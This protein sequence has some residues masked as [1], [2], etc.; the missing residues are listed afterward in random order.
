MRI[1]SYRESKCI[2]LKRPVHRPFIPMKSDPVMVNRKIGIAN[3]QHVKGNF[4]TRKH[5]HLKL[6]TRKFTILKF[7]LVKISTH[8]T[9]FP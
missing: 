4:A 2:L 6:L 5:Y 1:L 9:Q 7:Q 8:K 3:V